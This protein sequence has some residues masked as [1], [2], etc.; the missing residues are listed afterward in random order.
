MANS[1]VAVTN[2]R[3]TLS[4]TVPKTPTQTSGVDL[5]SVGLGVGL[6]ASSHESRRH[7][8]VCGHARLADLEKSPCAPVER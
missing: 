3:I 5:P 6:T 2:Q 8:A 7:G 1:L 4:R